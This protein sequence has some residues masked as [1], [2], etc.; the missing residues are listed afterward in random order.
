MEGIESKK[1]STLANPSMTAQ[2]TC[3]TKLVAAYVPPFTAPRRAFF[4][5][6][7]DVRMLL[8]RRFDVDAGR[9][10]AELTFPGNFVVRCPLSTRSVSTTITRGPSA[11]CPR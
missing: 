8:G 9:I 10:D 11:D 4:T 2:E 3:C 6:P 7:G 1:T 5:S